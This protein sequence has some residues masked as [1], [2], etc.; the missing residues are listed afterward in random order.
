M[1]HG[2]MDIVRGGRPLR[3]GEA[4]GDNIMWIKGGHMKRFAIITLLAMATVAAAEE[5]TVYTDADLSKYSGS[6]SEMPEPDPAAIKAQKDYDKSLAE[7]AEQEKRDRRKAEWQDQL[8]R[9]KEKT[10]KS[11]KALDDAIRKPTPQHQ[12]P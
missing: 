9:S 7:Q 5:P 8:R 4:I 11:R 3:M 2:N 6:A 10:D 1:K 12:F